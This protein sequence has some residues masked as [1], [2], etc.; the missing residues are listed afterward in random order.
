[1]KSG[2]I[3]EFGEVT[4]AVGGPRFDDVAPAEGP[5]GD[6]GGGT[7]AGAIAPPE[8]WTGRPPRR[9]LA[10]IYSAAQ[11]RRML[12]RE[13]AR[14]DRSGLGFSL[15]VFD[16][17]A[18][19]DAARGA[20]ARGLRR[21]AAA[22]L[23]RA[24]ITDEVGWFDQDRVCALL[25][26]TAP[27]GARRFAMEVC[28]YLRDRGAPKPQVK[29]FGYAA[30]PSEP[31]HRNPPHGKDRD[32]EDGQNGNG[33][34]NRS[35]HGGPSRIHAQPSRATKCAN[36]V[37]AESEEQFEKLV[38]R[39]LPWWKRAT[40]VVG[41][42]TA[43]LLFCPLMLIA[44]A[45]VKITSR[46]PVIFR[47]K[48]AGLGGREFVM[49]KFR[50][51]VADAES[52]RDALLHR[53]EQDGPA[54][55]IKNDPRI[56]KV[57]RFLRKTSLDE[58]PQLFN[59]L[60]GD[61]TLVGPR[62]LPVKEQDQCDRWHRR[63]LSVTPGLTC[64]WQVEGRNEVYFDQ[65]MRMDLSYVRRRGFWYDLGIIL[66]TVPAVLLRRGAR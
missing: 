56:T 58:L 54:F 38:A 37:A 27:A 51:M 23:R 63:R 59:V 36:I 25:P 1:M 35:D 28:Q 9:R 44:A 10:E 17:N 50:T 45:A 43:I 26:D 41:A 42:L 49:F 46:G 6:N 32:G 11:T 53:N 7:A 34:S 33:G 19:S 29:I 30:E 47:Q 39:P 40:D 14:A 2:S 57:G 65:W 3:D 48:R 66:R 55:K 20:T 24:R 12:D 52:R 60:R 15:V 8:E 62:P 31:P 61:M 18:P 4:A 5:A 64:I 16:V 22:V 21:V 13:R